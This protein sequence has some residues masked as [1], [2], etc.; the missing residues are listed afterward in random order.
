[1]HFESFCARWKANSVQAPPPNQ[2]KQGPPGSSPADSIHGEAAS[3][4]E[5]WIAAARAQGVY[6][7]PASDVECE[8]E[9]NKPAKRTSLAEIKTGEA[10]KEDSGGGP[11]SGT[12]APQPAINGHSDQSK[13][14]EDTTKDSKPGQAALGTDQQAFFI[15]TQPT[16]VDLP[17]ATKKASKRSSPEQAL[18][19]GSKPKKVKQKHEGS[20]PAPPAPGQIEREDITAEVDAR[21]K[22]KEARRKRKVEKKRKRDSEELTGVLGETVNE[23]TKSDKPKKKKLKRDG[24]AKGSEG[25]SKKRLVTEEGLEDGKEDKKTKRKKHKVTV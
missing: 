5:T 1:M 3:E 25:P 15:D 23:A 9:Q 11:G 18:T 13:P 4:A 6:L 8:T 7:K 10:P 17:F 22:E 20:P 14:T 12:D 2:R 21:M 24:D 16:P 19:E